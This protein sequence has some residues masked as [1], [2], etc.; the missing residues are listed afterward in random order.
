MFRK[1]LLIIGSLLTVLFLAVAG[2]GWYAVWT[3]HETS[4]MLVVDTLPGL[5]DAGLAHERMHDNRHAMHLMIMV[6][7]DV[8]RT[9]LI[10][11]VKANSTDALW[12]DYANSIFQEDD[13]NNYQAMM[14]VRSNYLAS[15]DKFL[16]LVKTSQLTAAQVL[17]EGDLAR[18]FQS[19]RTAVKTLFDYNAQQGVNRSKVITRDIGCA[20]WLISGLCLLI[21]II[22][23]VFGLRSAWGG[24]K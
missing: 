7:T 19:Y 17:F 23:F 9:R 10:E 8:E 2:V 12:Q 22:G 6:P 18:Q 16:G 13:R 11:M 21:F 20:P 24:G 3:L 1:E 15:A 14:S 4:R 5:V